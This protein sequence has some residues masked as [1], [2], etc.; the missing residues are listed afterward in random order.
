MNSSSYLSNIF[1]IFLISC[2]STARV[3]TSTSTTI[4]SAEAHF[5][6]INI[7]TEDEAIYQKALTDIQSNRQGSVQVTVQDENGNPLA[8]YQVKY[9]QINSDFL[10]GAPAD[11]LYAQTLKQAGINILDVPMSWNMLQPEDK[12][13]DLESV[14]SRLGIDQLKAEGWMLRANNL[15][16]QHDAELPIFFKNITHAEFLGKL[17]ISEATVAKRFAPSID[18]WEAIKDPNHE[19]HNPLNKLPNEYFEAMSTS[20]Y[21]IRDADPDAITEITYSN[22]CNELDDQGRLQSLQLLLDNNVDFDILNLQF[23]YNPAIENGQASTFT[24]SQMS[25]C[26][27]AFQTMLLPYEKKITLEFSAPSTTSTS[28]T[29]YW[30]VPWSEDTQAQYLVTAYSIFFSKPSL[31]G[32]TWGGVSIPESGLLNKDGT[33]KKSYQA[34]QELLESWRT[35]GEALTDARGTVNIQGFGG[36]YEIEVIN[37]ANGTS[38]IAQIHIKEQVSV[39]ETIVG[40]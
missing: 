32:L 13:F 25:A 14:N 22:P 1:F 12:V 8:G 5:K 20:V 30:N 33:L 9:R 28:Q 26:Y 15:Y 40:P 17:Y 35:S 16:S 18:Y 34:L 37:P 2:S 31:Q 3:L 27:D 11:I 29:G 4:P 38:M 21:A 19:T 6:Y 7:S 36:D 10:F 39:S 23:L 24:F